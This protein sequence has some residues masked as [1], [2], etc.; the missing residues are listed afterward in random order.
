M[1]RSRWRMVLMIAVLAVCLSGCDFFGFNSWEWR[2]RLVLEVETPNGLVSGGSVVAVKAGTTPKWLPGE[3]A[4][5]MGSK[6][7][8]E[9]SFVEVAPGRHL[10]ALLGN[11]RELAL[12]IFFPESALS[13]FERAERLETLREIRELPR[14]RYPLLVTFTNI[15]DPKTAKRVDPNDLATAFGPGVSLKRITLEITN[16]KVT[17]GRVEAAIGWW[18]EL[19]TPI[20]GDAKRPFGDPVYRLGKWDF[21]KE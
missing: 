14:E 18:N 2:Q 19:S 11:E 17:E 1:V 15:A 16:D 5:G 12:T 6:T 13:T 7:E 9:A 3:G 8:G 21:V 4:G 20:G 10:F